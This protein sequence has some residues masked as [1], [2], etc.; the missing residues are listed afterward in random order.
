MSERREWT[1]PE[2]C[3]YEADTYMLTVDLKTGESSVKNVGLKKLLPG[4]IMQELHD[5]D[6]I[7]RVRVPAN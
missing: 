6:E 4:T 7:C 1:V 3:E 5:G 2:G